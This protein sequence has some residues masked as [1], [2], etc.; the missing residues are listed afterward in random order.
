ML[1][2]LTIAFRNMPC[3]GDR[4]YVYLAV[5]IACSFLRVLD[6]DVLY[7]CDAKNA[8]KK[9]NRD[10]FFSRGT[11]TVGARIERVHE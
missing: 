7:L 10:I 5:L 4:G 9:A 2:K 11:Y 3:G 6:G 1:G 8:R